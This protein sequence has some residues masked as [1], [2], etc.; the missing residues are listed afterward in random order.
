MATGRNLRPP[1]GQPYATVGGLP[2]ELQRVQD[3]ARN[4]T[5]SARRDQSAR[6]RTIESVEVPATGSITV[7]HRLGRRPLVVR[8]NMIRDGAPVYTVTMRTTR[9]VELECTSAGTADLWVE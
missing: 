9:V 5:E 6:G 7:A 2:Y 3:S 8:T 4:A 1:V